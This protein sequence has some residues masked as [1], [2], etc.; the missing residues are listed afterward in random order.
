MQLD[1]ECAEMLGGQLSGGTLSVNI[2][3]LVADA[4]EGGGALSHLVRMAS[5][6][7]VWVFACRETSLL[8]CSAC[9]SQ[10]FPTAR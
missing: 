9:Q 6:M 8:L 10:I 1:G 5:R 7:H 4:T 3:D 2:D